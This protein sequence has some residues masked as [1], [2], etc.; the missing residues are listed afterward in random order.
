[1]GTELI[2]SSV[3]VLQMAQP[4]LKPAAL[5]TRVDRMIGEGNQS[6][7][8]HAHHIVT[9]IIKALSEQGEPVVELGANDSG[10]PLRA[11]SIVPIGE[12]DIF[13]Q[14]VIMFDKGDPM[15]PIILGLLCRKDDSERQINVELDGEKLV[16]EGTREIVLRCGRASITLTRAGKVLIQGEYVLTRSKGANRIKGASVQIN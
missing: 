5:D 8:Q 13:R 3:D 6:A 12:K 2:E 11:R 9:G 7:I 16:L 14:A 4:L 1:M 15:R 10:G